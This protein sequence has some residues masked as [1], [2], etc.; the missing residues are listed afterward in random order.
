MKA[1]EL[2]ELQIRRIDSLVGIHKTSFPKGRPNSEGGAGDL[3]RMVIVFAVAALDAYIHM[4]VIECVSKI[5]DR[6]KRLPEQCANF[7]VKLFKD[8][9]RA[10]ELIKIALKSD[11][12]RTLLGALQRS[13]VVQTFQKPD[14]ISLAF[15]M[16][17]I[18]EPWQKIDRSINVRTGPKRKGRKESSRIFISKL[19]R[20]RD[21]IVHEG[22]FYIS[23]R[24]QGKVKKIQR[25]E[26]IV[27]LKKLQRI[28]ESI[29]KMVR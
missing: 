27:Q 17:E 20:R 14:Q 28:V 16:M 5:M 8:E 23:N 1:I 6:Y 13:L 3:L 19:V 12:K 15:K 22:D 7:V 2:F 18:T 4:R 29:E 9:D 10:R 21:D 11:P 26:V 25:S 24:S